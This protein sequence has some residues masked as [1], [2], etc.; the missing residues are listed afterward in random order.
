MQSPAN[1]VIFWTLLTIATISGVLI[2]FSIN[3]RKTAHIPA[4]TALLITVVIWN[5]SA[6]VGL[7]DLPIPVI[8]AAEVTKHLAAAVAA[9]NTMAF[10]LQYFGHW[11]PHAKKYIILLSFLPIIQFG[12]ILTNP[13]HQLLWDTRVQQNLLLAPTGPWHFA[14]YALNFLLITGGTALLLNTAITCPPIYRW[15]ARLALFGIGFPLLGYL[16]NFLYC[17]NGIDSCFFLPLLTGVSG[18]VWFFAS[19]RIH[20]AR[21]QEIWEFD[22]LYN[23]KDGFLIINGNGII[24]YSNPAF[25][26]QFKVDALQT[27]GI[28]VGKLIPEINDLL[29]QPPSLQPTIQEITWKGSH[30]QIQVQDLI[31]LENEREG[32]FITFT[33]ITKLRQAEIAVAVR[34]MKYRDI[35]EYQKD[36]ITVWQPNTTID[37]ANEAYC[38]YFGKSITDVIGSQFFQD[39]PPETQATIQGAI[40]RLMMGEDSVITEEFT[41]S[42]TQ[43]KRWTQWAYLP[44]REA[45]KLVAIQSVGRDITERKK[46]EEQIRA[47]EERYRTVLDQQS[48]ILFRWQP[49]M[50]ITFVNEAFCNFYGR[51]K[52]KWIGRD[53]LSMLPK[54]DHSVLPQYLQKITDDGFFQFERIEVD[55]DDNFVWISWS[56]HAIY[57]KA[58]ELIEIQSVGH[59]ITDRKR[60]EQGER[61]AREIAET[62]RKINMELS[63]SLETEEILNNILDL[64]APLI[65]Y[66]SANYLQVKG[67][68]AVTTRGRGYENFGEGA[69][70]AVH[71]IELKIDE[72]YNLSWMVKNKKALRVSNVRQN[73]TWTKIDSLEYIESWIGAPVFIQGKIAGFFS[74]DSAQPNFF[75]ED[76]LR[77]LNIFASQVGLALENAQLYETARRR[78]K[79]AETLQKVARV[80]NTSLNQQEIFAIILEQLERVVAYDSASIILKNDRG[81]Q[82]VGGRGFENL[83][84]VIGIQFP[85]DDTTPNTVVLETREPFIMA[86]AP[87]QYPEF[88]NPPHR[89]IHG[90]MGVPLTIQDR[91]IGLL[92]MDSKQ[93]GHFSEEHARMAAAFASQVAITIE[94]ARL[95][96]ETQRLSITDPL[97]L[98][99]NRRYFFDQAGREKDRSKRYDRP[100]SLIM[101]D[102]DHFKYINDRL[103]HRAGDHV[104]IHLVQ[105]IQA[106]LRTIDILGRYGGEEFAILLPETASE[107]AMAAAERIRKSVESQAVD[108]GE[109]SVHITASLGIVTYI[110]PEEVTIDELL[111]RADQAMY[112]AKRSGRNQVH[113]WKKQP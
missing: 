107:Q 87:A 36:L 101:L 23:L 24:L 97:T 27:L 63:S 18:F 92:V 44:I 38:R 67:D 41:F 61:I 30:F 45:N 42:S 102:L 56:N 10:G 112:I 100:M 78:A 86:D 94:N 3:N 16:L 15:Q 71:H 64:I 25:L 104:L 70:S 54:T 73:P 35:V 31:T 98:C 52:D 29:L 43:E 80:V 74:L 2:F 40:D 96:Q 21:N 12:L 88:N 111:D 59:D 60:A 65:P 50:T 57:N 28:H 6:V 1:S 55:K 69:I 85:N 91:V 110:P 19:F 75:T 39:R 11:K 53:F 72:V 103:G 22:L 93:V 77:Y 7:F 9:T 113:L 58:G 34:E 81:S 13:Q 26:K 99:Y 33:D 108:V 82:I 89:G 14:L 47:S 49:D 8:N 83:D 95:F 17:T 66:D 46:F 84:A 109:T 68:V 5:M 4:L 106:E 90:W 48:E 51:T 79:E 62:L 76:H 20:A 105:T 37:F 32:Q